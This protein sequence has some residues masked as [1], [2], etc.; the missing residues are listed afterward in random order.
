[1]RD[2]RS[3]F[4]HRLDELTKQ[5]RLGFTSSI[6]DL[7]SSVAVGELKEAI[8]R[9]SVEDALKVIQAHEDFFGP[10]DEALRQ[11]Y[12]TGGRYGLAALPVLTNAATA[13]KLNVR[14][15]GRNFRAETWMQ[16]RSSSLITRLTSDQIEAAR[17]ILTNGIALGQNP[18]TTALDLVGR[19][20]PTGTRQGGVLGLSRPQSQY[21][22]NMRAELSSP[23][24]M[25]DYFNKSRRDR[26]FDATVRR[27]M[28]EG[29]PLPKAQ[30]DKI[31][32]RYEARLLETRAQSVARSE[33]IEGFGAGRHEGLQQALD[34]GAIEDHWIF[35]TWHDTGDGTVR[36][37]HSTMDGQTVQGSKTPFTFPD[38]T[39]AL[40][41]GD[42]S[43]G[44]SSAETINCRCWEEIKIDRTA[45]KP[46]A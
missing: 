9:G 16:E 4:L 39:Q 14:F 20:G 19:V 38:G 33:A 18:T 28:Q 41:P 32:T 27:A 8:A 36:P 17:T 6:E 45:K 23:D 34:R 1:M 3:T 46:N 7:Q 25:S 11:A 40:Y 2:T 15:N 12:V 35:R 13:T 44:A 10:L 37:T 26:R 21:V 22:V 5:I 24:K 30:I 42:T 31:V 43:L 29:K